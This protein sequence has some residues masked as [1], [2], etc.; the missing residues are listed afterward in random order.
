MAYR[1]E[2]PKKKSQMRAEYFHE[3]KQNNRKER[4]FVN[5]M[6]PCQSTPSKRLQLAIANG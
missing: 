5:P 4:A 1:Q 6:P 3:I 2:G